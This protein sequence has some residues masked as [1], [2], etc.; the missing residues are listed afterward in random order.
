M[1]QPLLWEANVS[2][3]SLLHRPPQRVDRFTHITQKLEQ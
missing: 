3:G 2:R 1:W